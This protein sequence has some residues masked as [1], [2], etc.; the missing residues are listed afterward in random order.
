MHRQ[1]QPTSREPNK[2]NPRSRRRSFASLSGAPQSPL[3]PRRRV[4]PLGETLLRH[5]DD[6][7]PRRCPPPQRPPI[8]LPHPLSSPS[9]ASPQP[10]A[11]AR[12]PPAVRTRLPALQTCCQLSTFPRDRPAARHPRNPGAETTFRSRP[13][14]AL[15]PNH[16]SPPSR[17]TQSTRGSAGRARRTARPPQWPSLGGRSRV[18]RGKPGGYL[19][20][21][22]AGCGALRRES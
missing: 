12:S 1:S 17:L 18:W 2:H 5:R 16:S 22:A 20:S 8:V 13:A 11:R 4:P 15:R 21:P 3:T 6:L 10:A 7:V 19:G 14:P 9:A